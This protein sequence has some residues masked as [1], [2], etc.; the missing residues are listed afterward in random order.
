MNINQKEQAMIDLTQF[1]QEELFQHLETTAA[2][3]SESVAEERLKSYGLNKIDAEKPRSVLQIISHSFLDPFVLV[4]LLLMV[5]SFATK[6]IESGIV[7]F[8]MIAVSVSISFFQEYRAQQSSQALKEM[9]ANTTAVIRDNQVQEIPMDEVVPGDVIAIATGDMIPADAILIKS[10]DLF[11]NQSSL[12]GESVPVEK[13]AKGKGSTESAIFDQRNL[14]FM[15]SDVISGTG[16]AVIVHTGQATLFGDIAQ[17]STVSR[18]ATNFSKGLVGV[19]KILIRLIAILF[20]VVFLLNGFLKQDWASAFFF[21]VAVAVGLTP[22]MLPMIV[23][24]NL[25]KGANLLA[26]EK[27]IVKELPAIQNLGA[28]DVLCTDKTGTITEDR[29]VLVEHVGVDGH[30]DHKVLE[31]A[32]LNSYYQTGWRNLMDIAVI[33]YFE[34]NQS[35]D[36]VYRHKKIDEIPFDF[37]RRRMSLIVDDKDSHLMITKGAIEEVIQVSATV[38]EK[39]TVQPLDKVRE[40]NF[41]KLSESLNAKGMRVLAVAIKKTATSLTEYKPADESQM[42]IVGLVG[43]LDP[44]KESAGKAIQN[45]HQHGV[46]VKVLTGDNPIVAA[47]VCEEVGIVADHYLLGT[48]IE[49][50]SDEELGRACETINLFAKCTPMQKSRIIQV[51]KEK[52]HTVGFMGDGINDAPALR[53]A[54]VGISVDTAADITKDASSIILLEKSLLVLVTGVLE[55]RK[56]FENMMKYIKLTL[57]SNF[58]NVF[59]ILIASVF[60]PF[61]PMV[62]MQLLLQN[63]IYDITQLALPWDN[64]D[65]EAIQ[66]PVKWDLKELWNFTWRIGPISSIFDILTF[67]VLWFVIGANTIQEQA[68]F[69]AGWFAVGVVTQIAVVH[70]VRTNQIPFIQSRAS[71]PVVMTSVIGILLG[72]GVVLTPFHTY[73]DFGQLPNKFWFWYIILAVGYLLTIQLVKKYLLPSSKSGRSINS[74]TNM[75]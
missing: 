50:L 53:M 48:D 52:G 63:V 1:S 19:S 14:I 9:I 57:S 33:N 12:T 55:G 7:M 6:D 44:A 13:T 32:F 68:I 31:Y 8:L 58:G 49:K 59:S 10:R 60:L 2:G 67:L 36:S 66:F 70:I 75:P 42:T 35:D 46:A 26:K 54:D 61:L 45:L 47:K 56:V 71:T 38:L 11:I 41:L 64:V 40:E 62:S 29:V 24:S 3:L 27:V 4:L 25:A 23:T 39:G 28:M 5:V 21:A 16:Q 51:L 20:P 72:L 34:K 43:F 37:S 15:G 22:E 30:R 18:S 17:Q 73:V 65:E 74:K 69:Q